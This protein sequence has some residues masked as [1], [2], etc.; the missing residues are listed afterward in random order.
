MV[1]SLLLLFLF[2]P[3]TPALA[4][5]YEQ[6]RSRLEQ[7]HGPNSPETGRATLDLGLFHLRNTG[8]A[9]A[10][11]AL[12]R[13]AAILNNDPTRE[14]LAQALLGARQNTGAQTAFSQLAK[15]KDPQ[16]A[17]RALTALA[18]LTTHRPAA[19]PL[20]Q[21]A[22]TLEDSI[23]R[24]NDLGLCFRE[25]SQPNLAIA[26][27][28]KALVLDPQSKNPETAVTLN[29]LASALLDASQ[30]GEAE[31]LQR[32]ALTLLEK[33]LGPRHPRTALA[34][35]NLADIL[36]ARNK[37]A[38]AR[39]LYQLAFQ[40]FNTRLGPSHPWT[41]EAQAALTSTPRPE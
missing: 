31:L 38:E 23:P 30:T 40:V 10:I 21:Q 1:S 27:F 12:S 24:R 25:T 20:Y 3:Q 5:L 22:I 2:Q 8:P 29:N 35:S 41:L 16:V 4:Q 39:R 19:C 14:A 13:A 26:Q 6:E 32:R 28:R 9:S 37:P 36:R 34:A 7:L 18:D 17:A 15:S 33:T 11:P